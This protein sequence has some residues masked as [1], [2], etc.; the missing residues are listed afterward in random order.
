MWVVFVTNINNVAKML[1]I[2][3][4]NDL[5]L[6]FLNKRHF[7]NDLIIFIAITIHR[8][9]RIYGYVDNR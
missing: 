7:K 9:V 1:Y 6:L 3:V 2:Y 4:L 5:L 8:Y